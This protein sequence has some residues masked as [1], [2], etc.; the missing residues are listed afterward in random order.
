MTAL[1]GNLEDGV[2]VAVGCCRIEARSEG[3]PDRLYVSGAGGVEHA[4]AFGKAWI[5]RVDMRLERTPALEAVVVGDG[6]LRLIQPDIRLCSTQRNKPLLGGLLQPV[7]IGICGRASG[8]GHLL[9][10]CPATASRARKK[11]MSAQCYQGGLNPLR[12]PWVACSTCRQPILGMKAKSS[13]R[14][15]QG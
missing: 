3:T 12:G 7:E 8:M 5:D 1:L 14:S 10:M 4:V 9:S 6:A 11:E 2:A 15:R 13:P